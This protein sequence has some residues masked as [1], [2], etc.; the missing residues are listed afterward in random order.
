MPATGMRPAGCSR[1][2]LDVPVVD[3]GR[4]QGVSEA[5]CEQADLLD[6]RVCRIYPR[7]EH[8]LDSR[9]VVHV[10]QGQQI[11]ETFGKATGPGCDDHSMLQGTCKLVDETSALGSTKKIGGV[12]QGVVA[13]G[14]EA[15]EW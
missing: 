14:H 10:L 12:L 3:N 5:I 2:A 8:R 9:F 1:G 6:D 13:A 4:G 15:M 7:E 11:V